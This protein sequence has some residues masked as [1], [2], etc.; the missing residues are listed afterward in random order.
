MNVLH[1]GYTWLSCIIIHRYQTHSVHEFVSGC[2]ALSFG[3]IEIMLSR[4]DAFRELPEMV[5][6]IWRP[7]HPVMIWIVRF[8][9]FSLLLASGTH[10]DGFKTKNDFKHDSARPTR[11]WF[12]KC[13]GDLNRKMLSKSYRA[14]FKGEI[15]RLNRRS[16]KIDRETLNIHLEMIAISLNVQKITKETQN[17]ITDVLQ[18]WSS[19]SKQGG[20]T[21][22]NTK[23]RNILIFNDCNPS[24]A[25][26]RSPFEKEG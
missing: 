9:H 13:L 6:W 26:S 17:G 2:S 11:Q 12:K 23:S 22:S 20:H 7:P 14:D 3:R 4:T 25:A 5:S 10:L 21:A 8:D 15:Y 18:S 19:V 16:M 24:R 1:D